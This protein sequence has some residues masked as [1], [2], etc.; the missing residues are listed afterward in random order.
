MRVCVRESERAYV[1][2]IV[3]DCVNVSVRLCVR[4]WESMW[5]WVWE[6]VS[7]RVRVRE[8]VG[9]IEIE[10]VFVSVRVRAECEILG[11]CVS[12][13]MSVWEYVGVRVRICECVAESVCMIMWVCAYKDPIDNIDIP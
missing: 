8:C 4:A 6:Y 3:Y 12:V 1:I 10:T 5:A 2:V 13:R 11:M 7:V 9:E